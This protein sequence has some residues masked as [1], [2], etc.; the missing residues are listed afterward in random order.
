MR[1]AGTVTTAMLLAANVVGV[2]GPASAARAKTKEEV[3]ING[4]YREHQR[5]LGQNQ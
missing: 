1:S 3:A 5:Q 4:T 2:V